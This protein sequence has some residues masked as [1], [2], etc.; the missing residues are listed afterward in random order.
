M[1][2]AKE[3]FKN[4]MQKPSVLTFYAPFELLFIDDIQCYFCRIFH[5]IC[6]M[7]KKSTTKIVLSKLVP[8]DSWNNEW[9]LKSADE[10]LLS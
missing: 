8:E 7:W 5:H 3:N 2:F 9:T 10:T 4:M 6:S 1:P